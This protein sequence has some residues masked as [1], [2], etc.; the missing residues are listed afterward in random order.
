M[1]AALVAVPPDAAASII[2][3]LRELGVTTVDLSRAHRETVPFYFDGALTSN[4]A[5]ATTPVIGLPSA[6]TLQ[7]A[8]ICAPLLDLG[9]QTARVVGMRAA[10]GAGMAGISE[11]AESTGRLLNGMEPENPMLGHRIAFNAVPQVGAFSGTDT[12][13]E[14]DLQREMRRLFDAVTVSSTLMWA[15]W[16]YGNVQA[17]SLG[18]AG[19][20]S[21]EDVR[22]RFKRA[23]FVKVI[24]EPAEGIYPMPSLATGDDSVLVGRIRP[25]PTGF[26]AL[27]VSSMD[28]AQ[29]SASHAI[30][31]IA[32]ATRARTAH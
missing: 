25:D 18:F 24:D 23:H 31:A 30:A 3:R 32:A 15:P 16:F 5:L 29:A 7:L 6:D 9:L 1:D 14:I 13:G 8:R 27:V 26:G 4:A 22:T 21:P 11:L 12:E 20:V 28:N 17:V 10:S 2:P 19:P